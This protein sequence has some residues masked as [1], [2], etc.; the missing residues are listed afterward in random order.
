[1]AASLIAP[2][3]LTY[4][5]IAA[6]TQDLWDTQSLVVL[7][8]E[9]GDRRDL[10]RRDSS[11]GSD[12][13]WTFT[14]KNV[15]EDHAGTPP[16]VGDTIDIMVA[17]S[18]DGSEEFRNGW[19]IS[20]AL[21]PDE[22]HDPNT[23]ISYWQGWQLQDARSGWLWTPQQH[24][25]A[26]AAGLIG[27]G[28]AAGA[29]LA[30]CMARS[31]DGLWP[32][33]TAAIIGGVALAAVATGGSVWFTGDEAT[34]YH[35]AISSYVVY[36]VAGVA[37]AAAPWYEGRASVVGFAA[38]GLA[39]PWTALLLH[40]GDGL[41]ER[42]WEVGTYIAIL[43]AIGVVVLLPLSRRWHAAFPAI[44]ALGLAIFGGILFYFSSPDLGGKFSALQVWGPPTLA[45]I[46]MASAAL[47]LANQT[48]DRSPTA[49]A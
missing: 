4:Q 47:R 34:G 38:A 44:L 48:P 5:I 21:R 49:P 3:V 6:Q 40:N 24:L 26:L 20:V 41:V 37:L 1:M 2:A 46:A 10:E 15:V 30:W 42:G 18:A 33:W 28:L 11:D 43:A 32:A 35:A 36:V 17:S 29:A 27:T 8:G 7:D 22:R 14:V 13:V 45:A 25:L 19:V 16:E 12:S 31:P 39:A 9:V 23:H